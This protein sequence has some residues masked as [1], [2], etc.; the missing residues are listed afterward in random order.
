MTFKAE[1]VKD[2]FEKSKA[3]PQ[4]SVKLCTVCFTEL[5][6]GV[7]HKC[8]RKNLSSNLSNHVESKKA[9]EQVA[10]QILKEIKENSRDS[11]TLSLAT[12]AIFLFMMHRRFVSENTY[13]TIVFT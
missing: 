8:K 4:K 6:K 7:P 10:S 11:P 12:G 1:Y 2:L 3:K 9:K 5:R 13:H